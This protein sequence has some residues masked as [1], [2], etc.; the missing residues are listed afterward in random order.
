[1]HCFKTWCFIILVRRNLSFF[2]VMCYLPFG[3]I[4]YFQPMPTLCSYLSKFKTKKKWIYFMYRKKRSVMSTILSFCLFAVGN[5]DGL[6]S[7]SFNLSFLFS[8]NFFPFSFFVL[9]VNL[10]PQSQNPRMRLHFYAN[11]PES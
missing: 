7:S 4:G 5:L 8:L 1:M 9:L 10:Q 6:H 3:N 11:S 2:P